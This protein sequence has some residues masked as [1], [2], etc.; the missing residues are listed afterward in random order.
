MSASTP[1]TLFQ[2]LDAVPSLS[3][4]LS[5]FLEPADTQ[6]LLATSWT[7]YRALHHGRGVPPLLVG[8]LRANGWATDPVVRTRA[9]LA[10]AGV[11]AAAAAAAA[12]TLPPARLAAISS[13]IAGEVERDLHR[14]FPQHPL[15]ALPAAT[16]ESPSAS[17]AASAAAAAPG[18]FSPGGHFNGAAM[19]AAL[20]ADC[21]PVL[22]RDVLLAYVAARPRVAYCQGMNYVAAAALVMTGPCPHAA[23]SDDDDGNA[24]PPPLPLR[25][26]LADARRRAGA[27]LALMT[28]L[29]DSYGLADVWRPGLPR[30]PVLSFT[31]SELLRTHTPVLHE[32]VVRIGYNVD[33]LAAQWLLTLLAPALPFCSLA[34][35]WDLFLATGWKALYR[36]LVAV[37]KRLQ[38]RAL[39]F[40][41]SDMA[42]M[43]RAW[44]D[45]VGHAACGPAGSPAARRL[46]EAYPELDI[47][48]DPP[49]LVAAALSV[50]VT[51][52]HLAAAEERYAVRLLMR[53]V[54]AG[55]GASETPPVAWRPDGRLAAR[56]LPLEALPTGTGVRRRGGVAAPAAD[57]AR[58]PRD[59]DDADD[60]AAAAAPPVVLFP[61][62]LPPAAAATASADAAQ[63]QWA[64][65]DAALLVPMAV[66]VTGGR[67]LDR[68]PSVR[69]WKAARS[70]A[71]LKAAHHQGEQQQQQQRSTYSQQQQLQQQLSAQPAAVTAIVAA[72]PAPAPQPAGHPQQHH[73]VSPARPVG[74][75]AGGRSLLSAGG[76]RD[77]G[78]GSGGGHVMLRHRPPP[79]AV[80]AGGADR[81]A[82]LAAAPASPVADKPQ[83][84]PPDAAPE[85]E[86]GSLPPSP[87]P[88]AP[89]QPTPLVVAPLLAPA[90]P[91]SAPLLLAGRGV[92][93]RGGQ[94]VPLPASG[95]SGSGGGSGRPPVSSIVPPL[96]LPAGVGG[97]PAT[98]TSAGDGAG[99]QQ[100]HPPPSEPLSPPVPP[101][102]PAGDDGDDGSGDAGVAAAS[103][104]GGSP[105]HLRLATSLESLKKRLV[106]DEP[107]ASGS[108]PYGALRR[109]AGAI[110]RKSASSALSPAPVAAPSPSRTSPHASRGGRSSG[111]SEAWWAGLQRAAP[112]YSCESRLDV[113]PLFFSLLHALAADVASI[114]AVTS[115][116]VAVLTAKAASAK[117]AVAAA[118]D[119]WRRARLAL[120]AEEA[121][122]GRSVEASRAARSAVHAALTGLPEAADLEAAYTGALASATAAAAG[123]AS[124]GAVVAKSLLLPL[125][126][127]GGKS[128]ATTSSSSSPAPPSP[129]AVRR[130]SAL[131]S[132]LDA[133]VHA[134]SGAWK[135]AVWEATLC[136]TKLE[137]LSAAEGA[138]Q[139]QLVALTGE[140]EDEKVGLALRLWRALA[141]LWARGHL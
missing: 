49:A 131:L 89:H 5:G 46:L 2:T 119:A 76:T 1:A 79:S 22:L 73:L 9:W 21:G 109:G 133:R 71:K 70:R 20:P 95:G 103:A 19:A 3:S 14:T 122:V 55:L 96:V 130:A 125:Q 54:D 43:F 135:R 4:A 52:R 50:K 104:A 92:L 94:Q 67:Y 37:L 134:Q 39:G 108:S 26:G 17:P 45:A 34:R 123:K 35:V 112:R 11:S 33:V 91:P 113:G 93:R 18:L 24:S 7:L 30:L 132:A 98:V 66:V 12:T 114:D 60:E 88:P 47:L 120:E 105:S 102:G 115:G 74:S 111:V 57:S 42:V 118:R 116:D 99:T 97:G 23:P 138:L 84:Q 87:A 44:K 137:E 64:A 65:Y 110:T 86:E 127:S 40:D 29:S 62:G 80:A 69:A 68:F 31:L 136:A 61:A 36:T 90:P 56:A 126:G 58:S 16:P 117:G 77:A 32:H 139:S 8:S 78:T 53:K 100:H 141:E 63:A 75:G 140:R 28:A 121:R 48:F 128:P 6:R 72:A 82:L 10:C 41:V 85:E 27:A 38:P 15:F 25:V 83:Q 59:D 106:F 81:R 124:A 107:P 101:E 51:R 129:A 13:E